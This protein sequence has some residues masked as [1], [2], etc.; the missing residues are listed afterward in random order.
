MELK[1]QT[2]S[3]WALGLMVLPLLVFA[4]TELILGFWGDS[5]LA[6]PTELIE[7]PDRIE[8]IARYKALAAFV[9]FFSRAMTL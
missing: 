4:G 9:F 1:K 6:V 8:L 3:P 5:G 7:T 2:I